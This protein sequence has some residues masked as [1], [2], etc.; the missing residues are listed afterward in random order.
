MAKPGFKP[1]DRTGERMGRLTLLSWHHDGPEG[2]K[3]WTARCE[4]GNLTV[5]QAGHHTRSCGCLQKERAAANEHAFKATHGKRNTPEYNSW[6]QM[7]MR[8]TRPKNPAFAGYGGRGI[9]VCERWLASFQAFY[10]DMGQRP[11][12]RTLERINNDGNYEPSN[13]RWATRK[14]Q[15]NNRRK[16][17]KYKP[18]SEWKPRKRHV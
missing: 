3:H 1:R 17:R 14:E 12:G 7:K 15:A 16:H 5:V 2:A 4:C 18:F 11:A 10:D 9:T 6:H 13:C 8:C